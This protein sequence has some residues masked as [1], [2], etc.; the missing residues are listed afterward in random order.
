MFMCGWLII[1][2]I[3]FDVDNYD[4]IRMELFFEKFKLEWV[5]GY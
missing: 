2:F 4:D 3:F 1:M 5:Y